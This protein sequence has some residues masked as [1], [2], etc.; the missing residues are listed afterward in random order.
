M[1]HHHIDPYEILKRVRPLAYKLAL[2][3]ELSQVHNVFLWSILTTYTS[4]TTHILSDQPIKV[5]ENLMYVEPVEIVGHKTTI[6][7]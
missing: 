1:Y 6:E 4:Y 2:P 3:L 7:E 5:V